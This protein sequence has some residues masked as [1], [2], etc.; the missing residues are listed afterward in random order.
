M[1]LAAPLPTSFLLMAIGH[2][3]TTASLGSRPVRFTRARA[4]EC[5]PPLPVRYQIRAAPLNSVDEA[6]F[7]LANL[8]GCL[9]EAKED[10]LW[11][12]DVRWYA[13]RQ[14][15]LRHGTHPSCSL[16]IP[17]EG[18]ASIVDIFVTKK[19]LVGAN[20]YGD[21]ISAS[22]PFIPKKEPGF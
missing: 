6:S 19:P 20:D 12:V 11:A 15:V 18:K 10:G 17:S 22:H 21:K 9:L 7:S 4:L 1:K 16:V 2:Y 13:R 3:F 8:G 5:V 14:H